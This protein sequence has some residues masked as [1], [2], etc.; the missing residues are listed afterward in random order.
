VA[1]VI[2]PMVYPVTVFVQLLTIAFRQAEQPTGLVVTSWLR[3][4]SQQDDL[5]EQGR[6]VGNSLHLKGLAMDL[7]VKNASALPGLDRLGL[8]WRGLGLDAVFGGGVE[9]RVGEIILPNGARVPNTQ[10]TRRYLHIELDGPALRRLGVD[11]R[12]AA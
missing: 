4:V 1:V 11:F 7:S 8:R 6:G 3:S 9:T 2:P 10:V 5:V 12:D